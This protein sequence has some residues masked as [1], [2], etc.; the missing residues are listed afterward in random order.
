MGY[1][2]QIVLIILEKDMQGAWQLVD[3]REPYVAVGL[4]DDRVHS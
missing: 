4:Q 2:E 1:E 3:E